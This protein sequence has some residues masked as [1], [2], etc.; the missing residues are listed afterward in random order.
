MDIIVKCPCGSDYTVQ[1]EPVNGRLRFPI[2][3]PNCGT[4]GTSLGNEYLRK[5]ASGELERERQQA[6]VWWRR[7]LGRGQKDAEAPESS[8][9]TKTRFSLGVLTA[10]ITAFASMMLWYFI[11]EQLGVGFIILGKVI[12]SVMALGIG[13]AIGFG[14]KRAANSGSFGLAGM[15]A[16]CAFITIIGGQFLVLHKQVNHALNRRISA[17]YDEMVDY[18]REAEKAE[19]DEDIQVL[20]EDHGFNPHDIVPG[21]TVVLCRKRQ[22][23]KL[24]FMFG[25]LTTSGS[26]PTLKELYHKKPKP[27][28]ITDED[29]ALFRKRELPELKIFLKGK[30]SREEFSQSLGATVRQNLSMSKMIAQSWAPHMFL[31]LVICVATAYKVAYDQWETESV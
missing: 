16:L 26:L 2:A 21:E 19:T 4:D 25:S 31:W 27:D 9:P 11:T 10:C 1:E 29:I 28:E 23:D 13:W 24:G 30:P 22:Q 15:A 8:G 3:C 20:L 18:A 14:T 7:L 12:G 6:N 5:L 17:S